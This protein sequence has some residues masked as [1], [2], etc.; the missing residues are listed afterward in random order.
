VTKSWLV[1][2]ALAG[3]ALLPSCKGSH[4]DGMT[5]TINASGSTFQQAYQETAIEAFEQT[6]PHIQ[7]NYG[8]GGSGKGRQ[9]LA[10]MV[11]ELAGTDAPY[12]A[13]DLARAKGGEILY[14]P[15]MLGPISISYNLAGVPRLQLSP[16]TIA[17]IF[18][19]DI[20][21][22]NDPAIAADTPGLKLPETAI[23]VAHRADGSGTTENF[24]RYLA[25]AARGTWRLES[26]AT[27]LWPAVTQ[28][29]PW[30][31]GVAQIIKSTPGAIGYVDLSDA[32]AA[33]LVFAAVKNRAGTY[34]VPSAR[35]ASLA[36]DGIEVQPN[37]L[38]SALDAKGAATYPITY[39]TWV[40]V[41][42]KQPDQAKAAAVK[43]YIKYL[44]T[45]GQKLLP[46]LDFAPL[47]A[48]L[49]QKAIAQLD[50]LQG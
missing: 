8:D 20:T 5:V 14:F 7:I 36:G 38:F 13:A 19:R 26:G 30:N 22:W 10:D 37:L 35:S 21:T 33:G 42:A 49:Q 11:V 40:I 25:Q 16:A 23:V 27:V 41:Y 34:V 17:K 47:P 6:H 43:A 44:I 50:R 24:T 39:Q 48:G 4:Q 32:K 1:W 46:D 28:A 15:L 2:T 29:G 12:S 31:G 9:D 45:D 18:Q 3:I